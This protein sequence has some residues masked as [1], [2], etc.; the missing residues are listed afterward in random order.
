MKHGNAKTLFRSKY[1]FFGVGK[2]SQLGG[3]QRKIK[4]RTGFGAR[5]A[6]VDKFIEVLRS[7]SL[8]SRRPT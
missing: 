4:H 2:L 3:R 6:P 8:T 1:T 7:R 5:F